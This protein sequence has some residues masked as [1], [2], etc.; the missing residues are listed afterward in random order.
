MSE[1]TDVLLIDAGNTNIKYCLVDADH[2]MS[3]LPGKE[4]KSN[5]DLNSLYIKKVLLCSVRD[6]A[7]ASELKR[8]CVSTGIE[9]RQVFT[10]SI[11]FG[12]TCAYKN[13]QTL[14]VDRWMNILAVAKETDDAILTFSVGTA[15]TVDLVYKKQH[16]GGWITP[17]FDM[18][19][20]ALF[21]NTSGVFGNSTYPIIDDFGTSTEDCVNYGCRALVNGLLREALFRASKYSRNVKI[22]AF[23]GGVNLI[24]QKEFHNIEVDDL[25][26]FKGLLRFV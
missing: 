23:G 21:E 8:H 17:G 11:S 5:A 22:K 3:L 25:L 20:K 4:I 24:N 13:F 7:F 14:G 16:I 10:E 12:T 15:M 9:F 6:L 19:K 1:P 2:S 18:S 26:V